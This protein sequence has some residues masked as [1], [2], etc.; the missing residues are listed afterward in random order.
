M[1][2]N[3]K[4]RIA[5]DMDEVLADTIDKLV[6]LYQERHQHQVVL[7]NGM[8]IGQVLPPHLTSTVKP[9]L[10]ER[11][12]FRDLKV[13][14]GSQQ[15]VKTLMDRYDVYIASAAME[16]KF[17]LEDKQNW[18]EE[19]F[20]FIPWTNIIFCGH[21]ILD[22]DIMIDDRIKNFVTF[23]GRKLLYSAPHN[24]LMDNFER[25]NNWQEIAVKLL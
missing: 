17:S 25:V 13:M 10:N 23:N 1:S 14:P 9:Y 24:M 2:I 12:F 3:R 4:P 19:H 15:I 18:L 16:F 7:T 6:E 5:I 21:K 8:E 20:P 11:G 22:V